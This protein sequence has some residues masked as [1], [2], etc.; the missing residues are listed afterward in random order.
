[1]VSF[2]IWFHNIKKYQKEGFMCKVSV[3]SMVI[4]VYHCSKRRSRTLEHQQVR[5]P[6]IFMC[7]LCNMTMFMPMKVHALR[8]S[9][10]IRL[11]LLSE[12]EPS[13]FCQAEAL[14]I[15]FEDSEF[16]RLQRVKEL[17]NSRKLCKS[18]SGGHC[19]SDCGT[20]WQGFSWDIAWNYLA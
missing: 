17:R 13:S 15:W 8:T 20:G 3:L 5:Q 2:V 9:L 14:S 19:L 1:M 10:P 12:G 18:G 11:S 6:R 16:G 7:L 4:S